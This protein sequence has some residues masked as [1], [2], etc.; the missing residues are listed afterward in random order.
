MSILTLWLS[1]P[2]LAAITSMPYY[3]PETSELS[4]EADVCIVNPDTL[5]SF[6]IIEG[7]FHIN[8]CETY[9]IGDNLTYSCEMKYNV[10]VKGKPKGKDDFEEYCKVESGAIFYDIF[11]LEEAD[12]SVYDTI[13]E[14][15]HYTLEDFEAAFPSIFG[16][17]MTKP[18]D[19]M[20]LCKGTYTGGINGRLPLFQSQRQLII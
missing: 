19:S 15:K 5:G 10:V 11:P 2:T 14:Y 9:R 18:I 6:N 20:V 7:D 17:Y 12:K 1:K 13:E 8:D 16:K 4:V 3:E